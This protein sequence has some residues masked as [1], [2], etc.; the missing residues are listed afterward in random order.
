MRQASKIMVILKKIDLNLSFVDGRVQAL[1]ID[2][3]NGESGIFEDI[4]YSRCI[5][6]VFKYVKKNYKIRNSW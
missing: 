6:Q 3:E 2:K 4:S 1:V 5:E